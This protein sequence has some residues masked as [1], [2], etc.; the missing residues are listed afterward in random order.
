MWET[1]IGLEVHAQVIS[2]SKLFS[3]SSTKFGA[4]PNSQVSFFDAAIPGT[5]P[6]T[7]EYVIEQ[8]VKTGLA[9]NSKINLQSSFDR[10]GYFYPDLPS[11]YQI[12]Q[13]FN[14]IATGGS[15]N[16]NGRIIKL[17]RIHIEQDAGKCIH[18]VSTKYSY[19]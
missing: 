6:V 9:L 2:K 15:L 10:K 18:D 11:G 13:F 14:P 1:V 7:N 8:A 3:Y 5:L 19:V 4:E 12:T 16:I 17:E